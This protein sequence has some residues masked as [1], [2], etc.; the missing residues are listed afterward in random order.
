MNKDGDSYEG[1]YENDKK[2]G[3]GVFIWRN[4]TTYLG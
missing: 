2:S 1:C 3:E 4:G